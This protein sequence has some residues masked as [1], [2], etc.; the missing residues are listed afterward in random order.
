M[1]IFIQRQNLLTRRVEIVGDLADIE[2]QLDETPSKDW[3]DRS[4]ERQGDEVLEALGLAEL[5]ELKRIDAALARVDEGTYGDCLQCG[6][7][8]L[9]ARLELLP[10]AAL[11]KNCAA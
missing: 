7:R 10:D 3:E 2:G 1:N 6:E 8:I 5:N 9:E 11:C 4:V